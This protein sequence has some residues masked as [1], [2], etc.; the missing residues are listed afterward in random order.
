VA[1]LAS[2][3]GLSYA[4][5]VPALPGWRREQRVLRAGRGAGARGARSRRRCVEAN[6]LLLRRGAI[7]KC[8]VS[9]AAS[10]DGACAAGS[11]GGTET[12]PDPTGGVAS[13]KGG[14]WR[15]VSPSSNRCLCVVLTA[16]HWE[17]MSG[18]APLAVKVTEGGRNAEPWSAG[19]SC[20][21]PRTA[22]EGAF[23]GPVLARYWQGWSKA[24]AAVPLPLP[25]LG[26]QHGD[27]QAR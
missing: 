20:L 23:L 25:A 16:E 19:L 1:E 17:E 27:A 6:C 4:R 7:S 12:P 18:V 24:A 8:G 11:T 9:S 14:G 13:A 5:V 22:A 10:R 3:E 2:Q 21:L 15:E 26:C